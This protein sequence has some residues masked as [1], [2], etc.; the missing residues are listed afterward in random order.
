MLSVMRLP[1]R[2]TLMRSFFR[3]TIILSATL[4]FI[5]EPFI[6]KFILPYFGGGSGVWSVCLLFFTVLMLAGY[7]YG[8]CLARMG[9]LRAL[10]VHV[11]TLFALCSVV[12]GEWFWFGI[13][14]LPRN[15]M[16]FLE[17]FTNMPS[18]AI[19]LSLVLA[20]GIPF[21]LLSTTL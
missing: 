5:V 11:V 15:P 19:L 10:S 1:E 2:H 21:F 17:L 3:F 7:F 4:L 8:A 20:V 13:P 9:T 12:I 18:V 16:M 14:L 6:G